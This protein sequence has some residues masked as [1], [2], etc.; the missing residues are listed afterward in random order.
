VIDGKLRI[1]AKRP[2]QHSNSPGAV[3]LADDTFTTM[4]LD[5]DGSL[6]E[7]FHT[8]PSFAETVFL[9]AKDNAHRRPGRGGR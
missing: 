3:R 9:A 8:N 5:T 7:Q 1:L 6:T 2:D 4:W